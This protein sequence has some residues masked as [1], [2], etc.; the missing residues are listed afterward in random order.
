[1]KKKEAVATKDATVA[2]AEV[3]VEVAAVAVAIVAPGKVP[4]EAVAAADAKEE[5][6]T[7]RT[8]WISLPSTLFEYQLVYNVKGG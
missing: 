5:S 4:A 1:M 3:A 8:T 7:Q 2:E 6:S